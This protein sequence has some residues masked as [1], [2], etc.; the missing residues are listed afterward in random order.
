MRLLFPFRALFLARE[1]YLPSLGATFS[2]PILPMRSSTRVARFSAASVSRLA[3]P[4]G[5]RRELFEAKCRF[6]VFVVEEGAGAPAA[7]LPSAFVFVET[8]VRDAATSS[9]AGGR[10]GTGSHV[11]RYSWFHEDP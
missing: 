4:T 2:P 11:Q 7:D 5:L 9:T 8:L 6:S 1:E 3:S 10:G